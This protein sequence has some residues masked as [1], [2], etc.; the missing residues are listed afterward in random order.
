MNSLDE[1]L[2]KHEFDLGFPHRLPNN[3]VLLL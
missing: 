1:R 2:L 3:Y